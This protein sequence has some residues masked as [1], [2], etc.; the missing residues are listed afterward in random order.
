MSADYEAST[1]NLRFGRNLNHFEERLNAWLCPV[2]CCES[3]KVNGSHNLAF[4]RKGRCSKD[5]TNI[6][7]GFRITVMPK[8]A[9]YPTRSDSDSDLTVGVFR[10]KLRPVTKKCSHSFEDYRPIYLVDLGDNYAE[11]ARA[12]ASGDS[13]VTAR[14]LTQA[15]PQPVG[16]LRMPEM[17]YN[18]P[19]RFSSP[20]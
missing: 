18:F 17:F 11:R 19:D 16:R 10:G 20:C 13:Y 1:A 8:L 2:I 6:F 4:K 5:M 7:R 15:S 12:P 3:K 9:A 14:R